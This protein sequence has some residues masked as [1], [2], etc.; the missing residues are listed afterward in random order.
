MIYWFFFLDK[1]IKFICM[2]E[3]ELVPLSSQTLTF[4]LTYKKQERMVAVPGT[5][6]EEVPQDGNTGDVCQSVSMGSQLLWGPAYWK[7]LCGWYVTSMAGPVDLC[8]DSAGPSGTHMV[9]EAT[10]RATLTSHKY[11]FM[12]NGSK[13][14]KIRVQPHNYITLVIVKTPHGTALAVGQRPHIFCSYFQQ[15]IKKTWNSTSCSISAQSWW[16]SSQ[17]WWESWWEESLGR[18]KRHWK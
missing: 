18:K 3:L 7:S 6:K 8:R 10:A 12:Q 4:L 16:E 14:H 1:I 5:Q 9:R 13:L 11:P 15:W 2:T 17:S